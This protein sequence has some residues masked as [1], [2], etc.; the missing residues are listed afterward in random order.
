MSENII[1]VVPVE[2]KATKKF[3]W[4]IVAG[5]GAAAALIIGGLYA[6]GKDKAGDEDENNLGEYPWGTDE[7][8]TE[9]VEDEETVEE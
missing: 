6:F 8:E 9:E 4:K 7:P 5:I 2:K 1:E 3:G